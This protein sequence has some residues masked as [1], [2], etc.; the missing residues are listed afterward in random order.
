MT[1]REQTEKI[2]RETLSP[3][4]SLSEN[5]KGRKEPH[6]YNKIARKFNLK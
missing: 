3:F 1:I 6:K 2:E 5:T 4:A